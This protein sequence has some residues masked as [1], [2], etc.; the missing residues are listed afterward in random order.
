MDATALSL[1]TVDEGIKISAP[2]N[3][4][5]RIIFLDCI[6]GIALLGILIMNIM[7]QSQPPVFYKALNLNQPITG[8]NFWSW[9][10]ECLFFEGTMRGLFSILFGA[11]TLLL[12]NRLQKQHSGLVPADI[13]YRRLL[14]LRVW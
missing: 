3:K 7:S 11:G 9:V 14:W 12:L 1:Q 4:N 8:L 10:I 13:Y 2:V 6:R 5:D